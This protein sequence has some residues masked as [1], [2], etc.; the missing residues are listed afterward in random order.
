[1]A[2]KIEDIRRANLFEG[3]ASGY[4]DVIRP[5]LLPL[6]SVNQR[7]PYGPSVMRYGCAF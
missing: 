6:D 3:L 7:L 4:D 5:I 1:M 2:V